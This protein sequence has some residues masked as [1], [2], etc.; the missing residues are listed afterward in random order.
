M[1]LA[2]QL[3]CF[4]DD[5]VVFE[6]TNRT[7]A[8]IKSGAVSWEGGVHSLSDDFR[9]QR[10]IDRRLGIVAAYELVVA[11]RARMHSLQAQRPE[12]ISEVC[13]KHLSGCELDAL[14]ANHEALSRWLDALCVR[15]PPRQSTREQTFLL[16]AAWATSQGTVTLRDL[17]NKASTGPDALIGPLGESGEVPDALAAALRSIPDFSFEVRRNHL[18]FA[19]NG[20]CGY[21]AHHCLSEEFKAMAERIVEIRPKNFAEVHAILRG[22]P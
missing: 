12:D 3:Q 16:L 20:I 17:I 13:V 19:C 10:E 11:D 15:H 22:E 9:M 21:A 5:L 8:Q 18:A 6:P 2:D 7:M 14:F 4:V 1:R